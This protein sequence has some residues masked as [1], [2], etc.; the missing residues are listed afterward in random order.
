MSVSDGS[1]S[2][3]CSATVTVKD[4]ENPT[5]SCPKAVTVECTSGHGCQNVTPGTATAADN[6]SIASTTNAQAAC[7]PLG[8]TTTAYSTVDGSGNAASCTSSVTV[9]DNGPPVV[10]VNNNGAG[11]LWPPNHKM[12][13]IGLDQCGITVNDACEGPIALGNAGATIT[14]VTSDEL[15]D[16]LGDGHTE[17]D[18]VF[19][20]ATHVQ[21]REE[22]SGKLDGRVYKIGFTVN[23][24]NGNTTAGV[25][26]VTVPHDQ[27]PK[28][29]A[30]DSGV[31]YTV[32]AP[33]M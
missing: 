18:I 30:V 10:S 12:V 5:I 9:S 2:A 32:C 20:D 21:V 28:G 11:D 17:T 22:R 16:S 19:V 8:T 23:D 1:E 6:C 4:C 13:T 25:C 31:K 26:R 7:F 3:M 15:P 24:G 29:A 33:G 14:C 27:G